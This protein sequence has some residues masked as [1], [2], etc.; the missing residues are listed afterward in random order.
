VEATLSLAGTSAV[1]AWSLA[2]TTAQ[3][4]PVVVLAGLAGIITFAAAFARPLARARNRTISTG[5]VLVGVAIVAGTLHETVTARSGVLAISGAVLF[6]AAE[7]ADRSLDDPRRSER[8]SGAGRWSPAWVLGAAAGSAAV[9]FGAI[10]ARGLFAN[11]GPAA[12]TAGT[13]AAVL[14]AVLAAALLRSRAGTSP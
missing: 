5:L 11:G 14:V 6:C 2:H 4:A 10:A 9:S 12:L 3:L 8:R 1:A 13:V 7:I